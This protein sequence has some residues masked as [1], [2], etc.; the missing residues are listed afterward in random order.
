MTIPG[1][2]T[3]EGIGAADNAVRYSAACAI[4]HTTHSQI[5]NLVNDLAHIQSA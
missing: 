3:D 5:E 1:Y 4:G 2:S